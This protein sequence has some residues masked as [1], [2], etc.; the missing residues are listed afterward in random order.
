VARPLT[1]GYADTPRAGHIGGVILYLAH[2]EDLLNR[3]FQALIVLAQDEEAARGIIAREVMGF[4]VDD[5]ESVKDYPRLDA[6]RAVIAR[7]TIPE[8]A[9]DR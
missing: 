3:T 2:G 1:A 4:R 7:I 8:P 6:R 9:Q 5:I